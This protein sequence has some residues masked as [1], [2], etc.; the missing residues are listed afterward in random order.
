ML[1][2]QEKFGEHSIPKLLKGIV[3]PRPIAWI[4]SVDEAGILN[5]A[6]F[7]F[8]TVASIHPPMLSITIG[9]HPDRPKDTLANIQSTGEFVVNVVN[10]EL[11]SPM[12]HSGKGY[13]ANINEFE[14]TGLTAV[15]SEK[16]KAPRVKESPVSMECKLHEI[17]KPGS[18]HV[19][20]GEV[21][22][23]HINDN[24]YQAGDYIDPK[25]L[26]PV[27]RMAADYAF[28]R[29]FFFPKVD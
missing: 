10:A 9:T 8:F 27:A 5:L 28:V 21:I 12:H 25:T 13:D 20:I 17:Y 15:S 26:D 24:V 16:V 7:S 6:P 3:V 2:P 22:C 19:V 1:I 29:E 14:E 18:H 11:A 23:F 4:S